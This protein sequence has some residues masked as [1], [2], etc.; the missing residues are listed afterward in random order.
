MNGL[1]QFP[2]AE[3]WRSIS[4]R[5]LDGKIG[6]GGWI[7]SDG[8]SAAQLQAELNNPPLAF[9]K[10]LTWRFLMEPS[11]RDSRFEPCTAA[12]YA[13]T[14]APRWHLVTR[15]G[16]HVGMYWGACTESSF[17]AGQIDG[18]HRR[19]GYHFTGWVVQ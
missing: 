19:A 2:F 15:L 11:W 8:M 4:Y 14:I 9:S 18:A 1:G 10:Q 17:V 3:K 13:L 16:R 7:F 6:Y 12:T 5:R